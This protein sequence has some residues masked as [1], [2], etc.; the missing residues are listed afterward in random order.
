MRNLT[1]NEISENDNFFEFC[2]FSNL[3]IN[4]IVS[5]LGS[6]LTVALLD[7]DDEEYMDIDKN[8]P[9]VISNPFDIDI[10]KD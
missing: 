4:K 7:E 6:N 2:E 8:Y 1:L 9:Y 5:N 3:D 10:N